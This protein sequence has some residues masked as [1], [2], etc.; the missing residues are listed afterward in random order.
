M[1]KRTLAAFIFLSTLLLSTALAVNITDT[2]PSAED[3][4]EKE[5]PIPE[6]IQTVI[7]A[8]F[9]VEE[10]QPITLSSLIIMIMLFIFFFLIIVSFVHLIEPF[11]GW[12]GGGMAF[13][14]TIFG[15][16]A[17]KH[18][19]YFLIYLGSFFE[20][21]GRWSAGAI[22]FGVAFFGIL[23]IIL[24]KILRIIRR[25]MVRAKAEM[26]GEKIGTELGFLA[27][28]KEYYKMGRG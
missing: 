16:R 12:K 24:T 9:G 18:L 25:G 26:E 14:L 17:V 27:R 20:F 23:T 22:F 19:T 5:L 4:L 2:V 11:Q 8:V 13:I 21:L 1:K 28:F 6:T 3:V 10:S 7:R 15:A